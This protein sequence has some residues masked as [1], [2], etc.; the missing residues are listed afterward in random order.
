[1]PWIRSFYSLVALQ[2]LIDLSLWQIRLLLR[3][4]ECTKVVKLHKWIWSPAK[5]NNFASDS[6]RMNNMQTKRNNWSTWCKGRSSTRNMVE[7]CTF[8]P[9]TPSRRTLNESNSNSS[10]PPA[11]CWV[12][13]YAC[14]LV[15]EIGAADRYSFLFRLLAVPRWF[16]RSRYIYL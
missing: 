4:I 2:M 6:T 16:V 14:L 9:G 10:Q 15:Q 11:S 5:R 3:W 1:M 7:Q 13:C 12:R 8:E